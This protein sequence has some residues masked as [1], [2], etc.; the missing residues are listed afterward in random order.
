MHLSHRLAI[1]PFVF[2][3][4]LIAACSG[5]VVPAPAASDE[6]GT[7]DPGAPAPSV[8]PS[9]DAGSRL[10]ATGPVAH[11]DAAT[12]DDP[13]CAT[14]LIVEDGA[15]TFC[16]PAGNPP[17]TPAPPLP[18]ATSLVIGADGACVSLADASAAPFVAR[19][20]ASTDT[21][22]SIL[23]TYDT[24]LVGEWVGTGVNPWT[25]TY[26]AGLTLTKDG[27][28]LGETWLLPGT[29]PTEFDEA[30]VGIVEPPGGV[31][32]YGGNGWCDANDWTLDA[33]SASG[34]VTGSFTIFWNEDGP[35]SDP[36]LVPNEGTL[37]LDA[38]GNRLRIS[39]SQGGYGPVNL[40]LYRACAAH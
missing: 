18:S 5:S 9:V 35:C 16:A 28:F 4:I 40:D 23:A 10:D 32:Y 15:P 7:V 36:N 17:K 31:F 25:P 6:A 37:Q 21:L 27:K 12:T 26:G 2:S 29:P 34:G 11:G 1:V 13:D 38:A 20:I 33:V 8:L 24:T 19:P 39:W 22:A 30:G 3:S 14:M